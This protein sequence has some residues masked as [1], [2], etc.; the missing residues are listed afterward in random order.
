MSLDAYGGIENMAQGKKF[1]D[2]V[3]EKAYAMI[4]TNNSVSYVARELGL[5]VSTVATWKA[6]YDKKAKENNEPDLEKLRQKKREEFIGQAWEAIGKSLTA[7]QRRLDRELALQDDIDLVAKEIKKNAKK[8]EEETGVEWFELL[9]LID[10]LKTLKACKLGE[11]STV[12]GTL[13]DKQALADNKATQNINV[14][15]TIKFEDIEE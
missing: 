2:D 10:K 5:P 6:A 15:G 7:V 9:N 11:L 8:I 3:K 12:I 13:Y 4:A 14:S 1:N